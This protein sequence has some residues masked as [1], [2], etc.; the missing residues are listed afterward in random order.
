M[1]PR[2]DFFYHPTQPF[3]PEKRQSIG[4]ILQQM[5]KISFQGRTLGNAWHLWKKILQTPGTTIFLGLAGALVAGGMRKVV[6]ALI[7]RRFVDVLVATGANLYHDLYETA[8]HSH[9]ITSTDVDDTVLR[10]H[11]INRVYDTFCD[12]EE[13]D[14]LDRKIGEWAEK[15]IVENRLP[16]S[17]REFFYLLAEWLNG[18]K[19]EEG[20]LTTAYQA[21]VPVYCPAVTDSSF[22]IALTQHF[23]QEPFPPFFDLLKDVYEMGQLVSAGQY[24]ALIFVGGGTPKNFTQQAEVVA[25]ALGKQV[26]GFHFAIQI[27]QDVPY[28]GGLSGC[29]FD[30]STS[31]GKISPSADK[32]MVLCDATIALPLL[33][34]AL[35]EW[36]SEGFRREHIPKF[37]IGECSLKIAHPTYLKEEIKYGN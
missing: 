3:D 5:Q 11:R 6:S 16:L 26:S 27:T 30:E 4:E 28:W 25:A 12:D 35:M 14:R 8:G 19:K 24:S 1:T 18:W 29:T 32:V 22:G 15:F 34:S 13:F 10:K 7:R 33:S 36:A 21:G 23:R 17:S 2:S 20:I 9:Y 31:W 37:S